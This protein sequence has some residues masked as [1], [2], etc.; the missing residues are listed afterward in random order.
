MDKTYNAKIPKDAIE[1]IRCIEE[2]GHEA[3]VVGG[4]VRDM[5]M[6][7][8]PN[9]W[10]ITTSAKPEEIKEIFKSCVGIG[11]FEDAYNTGEV[12][13]FSYKSEKI[14]ERIKIT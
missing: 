6:N 8:E 4:C 7:R 10:D 13:S 5:L 2:A 1:I 14:K 9:D 11:V 3:Y 12:Y